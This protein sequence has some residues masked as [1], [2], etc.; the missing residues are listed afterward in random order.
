MI[1]GTSLDF[2]RKF[3]S[4]SLDLVGF[5]NKG[6]EKQDFTQNMNNSFD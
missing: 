6:N 4:G 2:F 1:A 3:L 5:K